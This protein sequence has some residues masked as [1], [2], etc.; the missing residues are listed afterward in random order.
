MYNMI[1]ILEIN[2]LQ[3]TYDTPNYKLDVLKDINLSLGNGVIAIIGANGAGKTTFIKICTGLLDYDK[4]TVCYLGKD[5]KHMGKME[6]SKVFSLLSEGSRNIYF[7][8]TPLE[9]VR[10]FSA[11]RGTAYSSVKDTVLSLLHDLDLYDKRNELVENLSRGMQQKVAI[12]CALSMGTPVVFLDEPTLGLDMESSISLSRFLK[13]NENVKDRLIIITSHD[14]H[15]VQETAQKIYKL[16]NGQLTAKP[17]SGKA[18]NTFLVKIKHPN[19][20]ILKSAG[21]EIV[22]SQNMY[23]MLRIACEDLLLGEEI[24]KL[25]KAGHDVS[26]VQAERDSVTRFYLKRD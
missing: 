16:Q 19:V 15:F 25:N 13:Q 2:H 12:V 23:C 26:S 4:G 3:K 22:E 20:D 24:I 5:L 8:L 17:E 18:Y 9:N 1:P 6:K 21:Y 11:I 14:F 7:K 10:Y